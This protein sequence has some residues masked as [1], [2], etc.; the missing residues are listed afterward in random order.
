MGTIFKMLIGM[1]SISASM[2]NGVISDMTIY[3]QDAGEVDN[4]GMGS[5][6]VSTTNSKFTMYEGTKVTGANVNALLD[7]ICSSNRMSADT[8]SGIQID[9]VGGGSS[10]DVTSCVAP[11]S[12]TNFDQTAETGKIYT[13]TCEYDDATGYVNLINIKITV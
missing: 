2:F 3:N 4:S 5:V 12:L 10:Y 9:V 8:G 7:S 1:L 11:T 6:L 13:V